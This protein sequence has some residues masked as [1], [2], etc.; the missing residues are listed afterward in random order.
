M[1]WATANR[2]GAESALCLCVYAKVVSGLGLGFGLVVSVAYWPHNY[3]INF[4][5]YELRLRPIGQYAD[6]VISHTADM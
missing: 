4:L 5:C 2:P 3:R 6:A 1:V